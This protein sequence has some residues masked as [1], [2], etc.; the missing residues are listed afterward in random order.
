MAKY[1]ILLQTFQLK[2]IDKEPY[3]DLPKYTFYYGKNKKSP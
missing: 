3:L 1:F 2:Q